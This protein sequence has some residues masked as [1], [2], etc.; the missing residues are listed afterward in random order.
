MK[1]TRYKFYKPLL[2]SEAI[3]RLRKFTL[4]G[5][6]TEVDVFFTADPM[7][8]NVDIWLF[9]D[10]DLEAKY[11][12]RAVKVIVNSVLNENPDLELACPVKPESLVGTYFTGKIHF[13]KKPFWKRLFLRKK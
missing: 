3:R 2:C 12:D 5:Y 10:R 4:D 1:R 6:L 9:T 7:T 11:I 8:I 13:K